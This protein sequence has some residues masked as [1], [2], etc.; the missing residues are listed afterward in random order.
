MQFRARRPRTRRF[1]RPASPGNPAPQSD[2]KNQI[3]TPRSSAAPTPIHSQD[4]TAQLPALGR[5]K[6]GQA[7]E[8][9]DLSAIPDPPDRLEFQCPCGK[10]LVAKRELYN[11]RSKCGACQSILLLNIVYRRDLET[12]EIDP[13]RISPESKP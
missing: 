8:T 7:K 13:F 9:S 11:R 5:A 6:H 12:F 1:M 10:R 2:S 4:S 3:E